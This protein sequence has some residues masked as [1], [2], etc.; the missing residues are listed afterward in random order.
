MG[1]THENLKYTKHN[2]FKILE[3]TPTG[4]HNILIFWLSH[5]YPRTCQ[6][7]ETTTDFRLHALTCPHNTRVV[8]EFRRTLTPTRKILFDTNLPSFLK[9]THPDDNEKFNDL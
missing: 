6:C 8:T 1:P 7:G 5:P 9:G 4:I 3:N 2:L